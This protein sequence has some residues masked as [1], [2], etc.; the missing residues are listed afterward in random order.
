MFGEREKYW[1]TLNT[2]LEKKI[3]KLIIKGDMKGKRYGVYIRNTLRKKYIYNNFINQTEI[4]KEK[5]MKHTWSSK[6]D[7]K[8]KY[9]WW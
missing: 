1:I 6:S 8:N 9:K 4:R 3:H 2:L 7:H 5:E